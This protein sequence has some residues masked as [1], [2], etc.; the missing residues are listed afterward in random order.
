MVASGSVMMADQK[1]G[2]ITNM[3]KKSEGVRCTFCNKPRHTHDKCWKLHGKP[4]SRDWGS[5]NRDKEWGKKGD[6]TRKGGQ[7]H[8][9]LQQM[10]TTKEE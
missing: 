6:N 8:I 2:G 1:K 4:P 10:K 7:A 9:G 5:Q 3:E